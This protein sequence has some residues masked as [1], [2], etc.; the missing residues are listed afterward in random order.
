[1][2]TATLSRAQISHRKLALG[3]NLVR[4]MKASEAVLTLSFQVQKSCQ[5]IR[6]LLLSAIAN[7]EN[8]HNM[9]VDNLFV[10]RIDVGRAFALKRFSARARG[11]SSQILKTFSN[12]RVVLVEKQN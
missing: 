1:M 6:K 5:I 8:N 3:A 2:T 12:I 10:K 4:N 7:A 11:R 9:D